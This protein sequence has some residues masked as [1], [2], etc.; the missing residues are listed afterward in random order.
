MIKIKI[1]NPTGS[2]TFDAQLHEQTGLVSHIDEFN[3]KV[4]SHITVLCQK[5]FRLIEADLT[6]APVIESPL[7]A[8]VQE[9][10]KKKPGRPKK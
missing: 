7:K 4:W 3:C 5:G 8:V 9:V 1:Q 6:P 10:A 2:N